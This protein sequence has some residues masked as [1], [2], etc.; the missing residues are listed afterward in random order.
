MPKRRRYEELRERCPKLVALV[1][2]LMRKGLEGVSDVGA[3]SM[4]MRLKNQQ[5]AGGASSACTEDLIK[6]HTNLITRL[7]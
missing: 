5:L 1:E 7:I 2:E 3:W 6:E 4:E